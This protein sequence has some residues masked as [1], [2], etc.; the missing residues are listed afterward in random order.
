VPPVFL[1]FCGDT[2]T[3]RLGVE[4]VQRFLTHLAVE[5][6]VEAKT[7]NL[8]YKAVA[9]LFK[10][11]PERPLTDVRLARTKGQQ[12][13]PVVMTRVGSPPAVRGDGRD[14]RPDGAAD[15]RDRDAADGVQSAWGCPGA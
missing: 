11:V 15:V 1:L 2:P 7:Q 5:R 12:R 8:A 4:D 10:Q 6:S 14:L 13:L 9:F 3:E